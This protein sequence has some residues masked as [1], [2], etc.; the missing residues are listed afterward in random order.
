M[1]K[2]ISFL[3]LLTAFTLSVQAQ[4]GFGPKAG[5][6][7]TKITGKSFKEQ[8]EYN[9]LVGAFVEIGLGDKFA[10][11]P[12]VLFSQTSTTLASDADASIFNTDQA[13]AKLN[14]LS[15][16]ILA[17]VKLV[18]PLH[19]EAGP[20]YSILINADENLLKSGENAFKSGDFSVVA[21]LKAKISKLRLSAR[22]V[23]GLDDL[24]EAVDQEKWKKQ[25]IQVAL[26]FSF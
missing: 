1:I 15:I 11:S 18:G 7:A 4:F 16:P 13:K 12:E 3:L 17:N 8:F 2:K 10:V 14:Y 26:G 19:L 5:L 23:I 20:Q 21:G 25:S 22:Y 9:Y 6:N 24:N